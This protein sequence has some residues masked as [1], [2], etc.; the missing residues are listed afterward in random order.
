MDLARIDADQAAGPSDH[1]ATITERGMSARVDDSDTILIVGVA[2]KDV[3]GACAHRIDPHDWK[4][5]IADLVGHSIQSQDPE[6]GQ[7]QRWSDW[8]LG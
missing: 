5:V 4:P 8:H 7:E 1:L 3:R 6:C 2:G